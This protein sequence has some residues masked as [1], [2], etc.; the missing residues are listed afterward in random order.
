MR[1]VM[2][3]IKKALSPNFSPFYV[4]CTDK[5]A[6]RATDKIKKRYI[7]QHIKPK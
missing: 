5:D 6:K 7:S 2:R 1:N 4:I 3:K